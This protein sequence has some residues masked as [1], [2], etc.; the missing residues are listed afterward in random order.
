MLCGGMWMFCGCYVK[1][2]GGM[3][4]FFECN[5]DPSDFHIV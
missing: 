3:W 1:L 2:C 4:V 5:V